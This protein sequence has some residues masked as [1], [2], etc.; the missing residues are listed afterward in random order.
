[1]S[2]A[3]NLRGEDESTA[4]NQF[5]IN[6]RLQ[7]TQATGRRRGLTL[8]NEKLPF[9]E[10]Q[11]KFGQVNLKNRSVPQNPD[12]IMIKRIPDRGTP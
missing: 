10:V 3:R 7:R 9:G 5:K 11:N 2:D 6:P 4:K 12:P 1:M 8:G